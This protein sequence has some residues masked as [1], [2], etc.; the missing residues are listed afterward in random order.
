MDIIFQVM[1]PR[2]T[3]EMNEKLGKEFTDMEVKQAL[4][5]MNPHKAPRPDGMSAC[6]YQKYWGIFGKDICKVVLEF[7]NGKG[8]LSKLNH[9]N[10]VLIPK[11]SSPSTVKDFKLISLCN[12]LYKI[13]SKM[14]VNRLKIFLP[15][16]V[17][18]S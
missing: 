14:L 12:V 13:I 11:N 16:I 1:E 8:R 9:T 4:D 3:D 7:L 6:F 18:N 15:S 10:V 17:D 5:Q 2:V